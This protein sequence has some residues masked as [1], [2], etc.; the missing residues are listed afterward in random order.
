M[1]HIL[2][3][4]PHFR[5][6]LYY[7]TCSQDSTGTSTLK[8]T[9]QKCSIKEWYPTLILINKQV[10]S[11]SPCAPTQLLQMLQIPIHWVSTSPCIIALVH[12]YLLD[13]YITMNTVLQCIG[14]AV[15]PYKHSGQSSRASSESQ[16]LKMLFHTVAMGFDV[17]HFLANTLVTLASFKKMSYIASL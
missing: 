7:E 11:P 6:L 14:L 8:S 2:V 12:I 4:Q 10:W 15:L 1:L 17:L 9:R 13:H 16:G 3:D 5:T